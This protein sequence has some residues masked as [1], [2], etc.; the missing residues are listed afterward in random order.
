MMTIR[1]SWSGAPRLSIRPFDSRVIERELARDPDRAS[2]EYLCRWR[3][4]LLSFID[5]DAV[6]AC[7]DSGCREHGPVAGLQYQAFTDPSGGR[8]DSFTL[9]IAHYEGSRGILDCVR[10]VKPPFSPDGVVEEFADLLR[11]YNIGEVIGDN[12]CGR[13]ATGTVYYPRYLLPCL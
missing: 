9:A 1:W 7:V 2:A 6:E 4:D 11:R 10:E 12:L 3:D 13:L 8:G 5:R